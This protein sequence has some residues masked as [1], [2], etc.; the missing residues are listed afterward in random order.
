[1]TLECCV[2]PRVVAVAEPFKMGRHMLMR[3]E[4]ASA[5]TERRLGQ[6]PLDIVLFEQDPALA[7]AYVDA[8]V[9][10]FIV[11]TESKGKHERQQGFDTEIAPV[12]LRS[13]GPLS[14]IPGAFVSCRINGFCDT[15]REEIEIAASEGVHRIFLPMASSVEQ[16]QAFIDLVDGRCETAI[17]IE[18]QQ[19]TT[20]AADLA[21]LPLDAVYI[22]LNDLSI[23]RGS[24][25]IFSAVRDET[26]RRMRE[27]FAGRQFGF[28][29]VTALGRGFPIPC[30]MLLAEMVALDCTFTFARRSFRKHM[31]GRDVAQGV[32]RI[33]AYW[34]MLM[35]RDPDRIERDRTRLANLIAQYE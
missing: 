15:T 2:W 31:A 27:A 29:G 9:T 18:T 6:L 16:V 8:G 3:T 26:V 1:M 25:F 10:H 20:I 30:R 32:A 33:Q 12:S 23:S 17:L 28:A 5:Q 34:Q 4:Q 24:H 14:R 22:G 21:R 7:Q 35:D 11:D 13:V 19:A